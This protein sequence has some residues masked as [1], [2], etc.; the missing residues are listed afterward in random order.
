MLVEIPIDDLIWLTDFIHILRD[1][2]IFNHL[3]K[4]NWSECLWVWGWVRWFIFQYC[5]KQGSSLLIRFLHFPSKHRLCQQFLLRIQY[6]TLILTIVEY[7]YEACIPII[8]C[9]LKIVFYTM[10]YSLYD[11]RLLILLRLRYLYLI[12]VPDF[13]LWV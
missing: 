4:N 6:L 5:C 12:P 3:V 9:N 10:A 7:I 2:Y 8:P 13:V 1:V 11:M